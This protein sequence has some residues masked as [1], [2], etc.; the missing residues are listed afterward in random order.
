MQHVVDVLTGDPGEISWSWD[1]SEIAFF[2][3]GICS[4][5]VSSGHKRVLLP[6]EAIKDGEFMFW[7]WYPM[8]W[9]HG[10]E[11]LVV[12]LATDK[13]AKESGTHVDQSRLVVIK[14]GSARAIAI[15]SKPAVSPRS[16]KVAY[17]AGDSVAIINSDGTDKIE[18]AN[19]PREMF[20]FK[21]E[22]F[23]NLVWSP[24]GSHLFFNTIVSENRRDKLYL[25]D[26]KAHRP[27]LFLS[28]TSITIR[29]WH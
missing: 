3:H 18:L 7:V 4:V 1:D 20:F 29:G 16:D 24:D 9:L 14:D 25:L 8:Q 2:E 27:D 5:A 6:S 26:V 22:L 12:E 13:P 17:Y 11:Y 19:A 23:G 10:N 21:E 28:R 15:G